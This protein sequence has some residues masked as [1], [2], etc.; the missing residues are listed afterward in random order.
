MQRF[1][2]GLGVCSL[3]IC[4]IPWVQQRELLHIIITENQIEK[5]HKEPIP[6]SLPVEALD[7]HWI[8]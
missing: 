7:R 4:P 2:E 1:G 6:F 8:L 5:G 3:T